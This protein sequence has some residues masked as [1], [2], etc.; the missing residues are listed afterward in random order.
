MATPA[1][2]DQDQFRFRRAAF[3]SSVKSKVGLIAAKAAALR[4]NMNIDSRSA[5]SP[6]VLRLGASL[7]LTPPPLLLTSSVFFHTDPEPKLR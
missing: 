5:W 6:R 4:I 3:Y 7:P 1:Q 2:T